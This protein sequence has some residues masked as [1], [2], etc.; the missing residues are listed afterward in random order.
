M[1]IVSPSKIQVFIRLGN[2][3][4][5]S[6]SNPRPHKLYSFKCLEQQRQET[7]RLSLN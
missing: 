5:E 3:E 7:K 2:T 1:S 6:E 4:I